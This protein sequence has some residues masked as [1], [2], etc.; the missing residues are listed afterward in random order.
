MSVSHGLD[1]FNGKWGGEVSSA[2]AT[3]DCNLE[4]EGRDWMGTEGREA[5]GKKSA[6]WQT[7]KET[8]KKPSAS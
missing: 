4:H 5:E 8:G 1:Q 2:K 6:R 3:E 7:Y